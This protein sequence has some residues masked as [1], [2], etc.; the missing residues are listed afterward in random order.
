[1]N[2]SSGRVPG[3]ATVSGREPSGPISAMEAEPTQ[4]SD[5]FTCPFWWTPGAE[6]ER[7]S[8]GKQEAD[9]EPDRDHCEHKGDRRKAEGQ[10]ALPGDGIGALGELR[11]VRVH[12]C[13][14]PLFEITD[15]VFDR[16]VDVGEAARGRLLDDVN[17]RRH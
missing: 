14:Q 6:V 2:H 7:A 16:R 13:Q 9:S 5:S 4:L 3:S 15:P 17:A 1:M 8:A 11:L 12:P 10:A